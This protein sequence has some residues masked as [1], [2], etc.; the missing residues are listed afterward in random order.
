MLRKCI[1]GWVDVTA[2]LSIAELLFQNSFDHLQLR[3]AK[4]LMFLCF[5]VHACHVFV[6]AGVKVFAYVQCV[7][8]LKIML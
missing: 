1:R 4:E 7:C 5:E 3:V 6:F 8:Q 2:G